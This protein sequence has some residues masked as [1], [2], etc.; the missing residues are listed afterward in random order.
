MKVL[1]RTTSGQLISA[2]DVTEVNV[3]RSA[4]SKHQTVSIEEFKNSFL[5][6]KTSLRA[7]TFKGHQTLFLD[8]KDIDYI[9]LSNS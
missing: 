1:I 5:L 8:S 3:L 2:S 7:L 9:S 4:T 6:N